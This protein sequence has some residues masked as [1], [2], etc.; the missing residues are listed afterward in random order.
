MIITISCNGQNDK[1][2][3]K[4]NQME[5][6][7]ISILKNALDNNQYELKSDKVFNNK[8]SNYLGID[9]NSLSNEGYDEISLNGEDIDY[10]VSKQGRYIKIGQDILPD[11]DSVKQKIIIDKEKNPYIESITNLNKVLF[12]DDPTS[13]ALVTHQDKDLATDLVVLFD[14]EKNKFLMNAAL[15][16]IKSLDDQPKYFNWCLLFYND[17][18]KEEIIRKDLLLELQKSNSELISNLITFITKNKSSVN[19]KT[20]DDCLAFLINIK[21]KESEKNEDWN[22]NEGF[23]L[24]SYCYETDN[25]LLS[26]FEKASFFNYSLIKNATEAYKVFNPNGQKDYKI[27]DPDGYTNLR[28]DKNTSSEILQQIKSG[29]SIDVLE[30]QGDWWLVKTNE[31]KQGY[32]HKSRVK[33]N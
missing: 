9:T 33:A 16:N 13:I 28:K 18:K 3:K 11:L 23:G 32:V 7:E 22:T 10:Q 26:R 21:L 6:T 15:K 12:S 29:E 2:N 19:Q 8:I 17:R 25:N 5:E 1:K 4:T 20:I 30:N 24:L 31:G 27:Q 14:Y